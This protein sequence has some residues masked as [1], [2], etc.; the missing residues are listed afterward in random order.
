MKILREIIISAIGNILYYIIHIVNKTIKLNV[1]NNSGIVDF[2]KEKI[3][4]AVCY[5]CIVGCF[6][7]LSLRDNFFFDIEILV[8]DISLIQKSKKT[9]R[10]KILSCIRFEIFLV[11]TF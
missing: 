4:Y 6:H 9:T 2:E 10:A 11:K 7:Y 1:I 5:K 3:V 8:I